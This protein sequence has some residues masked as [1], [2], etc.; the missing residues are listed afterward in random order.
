[1]YLILI[2]HPAS[3]YNWYCTPLNAV[4]YFPLGK[5]ES[6]KVSITLYYYSNTQQV[7]MYILEIGFSM[8]CA[9]LPRITELNPHLLCVLCGGY[10]IDAT[11]IIECLHAC[12]N[13]LR[14]VHYNPSNAI[15]ICFVLFHS[16]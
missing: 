4:T 9:T 6:E 1:M 2:V 13:I 5:V 15:L 11:S 12:M 10:Y 16:L 7:F 14:L 3:S 8:Q